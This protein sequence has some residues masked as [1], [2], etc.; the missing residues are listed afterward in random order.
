MFWLVVL[1]TVFLG[2]GAIV[3]VLARDVG[4]DLRVRRETPPATLPAQPNGDA[5]AINTLMRE[6]LRAPPPSHPAALFSGQQDKETDA[7]A[8]TLAQVKENPLLPTGPK[9]YLRLEERDESLERLLIRRIQGQEGAGR[10][11][12]PPGEFSIAVTEKKEV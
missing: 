11:P 9:V 6:H 12:P 3:F 4:R 2:V 5:V 10:T 8:D 1:S 7:L